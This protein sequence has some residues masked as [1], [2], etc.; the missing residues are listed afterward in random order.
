MDIKYGECFNGYQIR[1]M[2]Q[3]ISNT[4]NVSM[5]IKYGECFNG[6]QIQSEIEPD[7]V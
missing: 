5:D 1:G 7:L 3:W 4:E 6:Y 2:F